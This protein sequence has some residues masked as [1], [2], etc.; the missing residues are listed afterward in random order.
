[1]GLSVL[2][3]YKQLTKIEIPRRDENQPRLGVLGSYFLLCI[4]RSGRECGV[5][6]GF[7]KS[8]VGAEHFLLTHICGQNP[9]FGEEP[10]AVSSTIW[11]VVDFKKGFKFFDTK[12]E[13]QEAF[14]KLNHKLRRKS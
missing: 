14:N 9:T 12:E 7:V 11:S 1:M 4:R 2:E 13:C 8:Q 3:D 5:L 6:G 10:G